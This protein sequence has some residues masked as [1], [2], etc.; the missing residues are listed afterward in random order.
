MTVRNTHPDFAWLTNSLETDMS[1]HLWLPP[2]SA[3]TALGYRQRFERYAK[4]TGADK[5]F[6]QWQGHDFSYRGMAGTWAAAASGA[7]HLLSFTGT[8]TIPGILFLEQFYG[9]NIEKELVGASVPA[10][11]HMVMCLSGQE[12]EFNLIKRLITEVYPTGIVSIVCDTWSLKKVVTE[13]LPRLKDIILKREG[14]VVIRPDSGVPEKIVNG[15]PSSNDKFYRD[16]LTCALKDIFG[17]TVNDVGYFVLDPHIGWIYGDSITEQRQDTILDGLKEDGFASSTPVL[18]VGSFTYQR[19]TRDT[20]GWAFKATY[21]ED[22]DGAN[23]LFKDPETDGGVKKSA[24][25]LL[26]VDA[27]GAKDPEFDSLTGLRLIEDCTW[28][29][30]KLGFLQTIFKDGKADN[31]QTLAD[32]RARVERYL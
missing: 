31:L 21:A 11:E 6:I 19:V 24:R 8:D 15:D 1:N 20:D 29:G 5:A 9:A 26:A 25:G 30:E 23:P 22:A 2:T 16:G 14:K 32:I 4:E 17:G 27:E 7:G 13:Y 28:E 3:T 10:T 18:G 12:G